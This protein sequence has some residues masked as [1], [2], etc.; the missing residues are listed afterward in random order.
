MDPKEKL[1]NDFLSLGLKAGD[2]VFMRAD[3]SQILKSKDGLKAKDILEVLLDVVSKDGTVVSPAYTQS[4]FIKR[5]K[6]NI[7]TNKSRTISGLFSMVMLADKNSIRSLHPTN[8]HV[9]I[10]KYAEYILKNHDEN[11]G[12]FEPTRKIMELNGKML[13]VG[14]VS[15]SLGFNTT[16]L[17]ETDLQL[18][19]RIILP[20]LVTSY[21]K[22]DGE[23]KLFKRKDPGMCVAN[24]YQLFGLYIKNEV[25]KQG[26]IGGAYSIIIDAKEAYKID[27]K[28]LKE[29]PKFN[30]CDNKE[31]LD[32]RARRWDNLKDLPIFFLKKILK[33]IRKNS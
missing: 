18:Q 29:N 14:C 28:A 11:A 4:N 22:K 12:A 10:G 5:D 1:K 25:L 19:N 8:S 26:Y 23:I 21:Y 13:L 17:A 31:C 6:K 24:Y 15:T 27:F 16:H 32:C 20:T 3:I 2:I 7:F 30:I 9:A 33:K